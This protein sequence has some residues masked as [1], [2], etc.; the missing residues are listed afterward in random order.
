MDTPVYETSKQNS[1]NLS[2]VSESQSVLNNLDFPYIVYILY[3]RYISTVFLLFFQLHYRYDYNAN[4]KG[5]NTAPAVTIDT[6]RAAMA[7]Y[8][9]SD[10]RYYSFRFSSHVEKLP[11]H[12]R[13][14]WNNHLQ[15]H[16]E[17]VLHRK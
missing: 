4:I 5:T 16:V 7:N 1:Q 13:L 17:K 6:Q 12:V 8:I 14:D 2:D 10:V 9:Q 3:L 15:Q 11:S